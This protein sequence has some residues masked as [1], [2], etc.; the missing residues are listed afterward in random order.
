MSQIIT[1]EILKD[2]HIKQP[3]R[4]EEWHSGWITATWQHDNINKTM[5]DPKPLSRDRVV[6]YMKAT[7]PHLYLPREKGSDWASL[8]LT[9]LEGGEETGRWEF[10]VEKTWLD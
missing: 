7:F 6:G 9:K 4:K 5:C 1:V 3:S 8:F 10:V 2:G